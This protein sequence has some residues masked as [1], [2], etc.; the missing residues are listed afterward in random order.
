MNSI[1]ELI[2]DLRLGKMVI[3]L[4]DED[5]ENEGDLVLAADAVTPEKI[6]FMAR[7]A[8]GLI[9]LSLTS[10]QTQKLGLPMMVKDESNFSPNKTAFTVSIEAASG[11]STGISAADRAHTIRVASNP[12]V[13]A[14]DI[15][16][17][18]HIFPIRAQ[19]GGVLKRAGHTEG[20]IDL[21]RLA[22]RQPAAVICEIMNDDGTMART[23]DLKT[24][25]LKHNLKIGTIVD[26]IRYRME[27][28]TLVLEEAAAELPSQFGEGFR[29]R[30]FKSQ[31]DQAEHVLIQKGEI[32]ADTP[33]LVRV[34]SECMTGDIFGSLRCDC[35]PQLRAALKR[36]E[37][38][39]HGAVLYLRQEGRG[40]G[41]VNKIKA[42]A[43]QD[44][45]GLDTVEANT[46]LGFKPDQRDYGIGAQILRTVGV[47][48]I[49][50]MTNNPAKR[51]GLKGY[52]LEIVEIVP[53]AVGIQKT[54]IEYIRTKAAKMG[55]V[56]DL[57][58]SDQNGL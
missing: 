24:F 19:N 34:H 8:R 33:T 23:E 25:A 51:I 39:G 27:N 40:I 16:M 11:V 32:S 50:L 18:G 7:E 6:N 57:T 10:Q 3:L 22:G 20:S 29:V 35:G 12:D 28:E 42:Y 58:S 5:R 15:I 37:T 30:V 45:R 38:E 47:G 41:L 36:I 17:P 44:T 2:E 4:D 1:H 52:G 48:K 13:K 14:S 53:L 56:F 55:H 54:N 49:R 21:C 43:L 46:H 26:L 9:C 31:V